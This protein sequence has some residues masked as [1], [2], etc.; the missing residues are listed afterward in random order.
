[1]AID[2]N[3]LV[4][5]VSALVSIPTTV[6]VFFLS[7]NYLL[8]KNRNRLIKRISSK[9]L[10]FTSAEEREKYLGANYTILDGIMPFQRF[11]FKTFEEYLLISYSFK[12]DIYVIILF[13]VYGTASLFA[14]SVVYATIYWFFTPLI[15]W[16]SSIFVFP[17]LYRR[18]SKSK[19]FQA[20]KYVFRL[21]RRDLSWIFSFF[22]LAYLSAS[23]L[24]NIHNKLFIQ[25]FGITILFPLTFIT[26]FVYLVP[27]FLQSF[28]RIFGVELLDDMTSD[29]FDFISKEYSDRTLVPR[30]IVDVG[31][32][33][34][35]Q[36]M[37]K[38]VETDV[39]IVDNNYIN[40]ESILYFRIEYVRR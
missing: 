16:V 20:Y 25:D 10:V 30:I 35:I 5:L 17:Y 1:M 32:K 7:Q 31:G 11:K 23:V 4:A 2:T 3:T 40:W 24:P 22:V 15:F 28:P 37:V 21:Y 38:G 18:M 26:L 8:S 27:T 6:I 14:K 9:I 36:G 34:V 13:V 33:E 39:L 12:L 19:R 29:L